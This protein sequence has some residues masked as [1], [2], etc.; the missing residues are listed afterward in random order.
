MIDKLFSSKARVEILKLFLF[1]PDNNY[2]QRQVSNLTGQSIRGV[3]REV[4]KLHKIGLLEKSTQGNRVYYKINK[5][6]PIIENL[7]I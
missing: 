4:D 5:K 2:Y 7:H 3:Q 6:C 1:N